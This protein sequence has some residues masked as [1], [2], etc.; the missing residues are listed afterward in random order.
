MANAWKLSAPAL[1]ILHL[2][3]CLLRS[4]TSVWSVLPKILVLLAGNGEFG[5]GF[6]SDAFEKRDFYTLN[7]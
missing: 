2:P 4:H 1:H 5:M 7:L 6:L 3:Y